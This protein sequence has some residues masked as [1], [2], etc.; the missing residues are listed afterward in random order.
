MDSL[1]DLD[2]DFDQNPDRDG[3]QSVP[4]S[5]TTPAESPG[6]IP[7]AEAEDTPM[8]PPP[9]LGLPGLPEDQA[10]VGPQPINID[11]PEPSGE[12]SAPPSARHN[13]P[14]GLSAPSSMPLD[15]PPNV[16]A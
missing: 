13:V 16:V 11:E 8:P 7:A 3:V 10:V 6:A 15:A 4:Y 1:D 2:L 12:P 9:V 5:P 14:P